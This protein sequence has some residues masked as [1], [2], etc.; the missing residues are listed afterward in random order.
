MQS[1]Y[2]WLFSIY[3]GTKSIKN[4]I[5]VFVLDLVNSEVDYEVTDMKKLE[6][7]INNRVESFFA[8]LRANNLWLDYYTIFSKN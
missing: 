6:R 8:Y 2:I 3:V 4:V 5:R 7:T 1:Q